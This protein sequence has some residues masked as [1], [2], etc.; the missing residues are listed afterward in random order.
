M[1]ST[2]S[3]AEHSDFYRPSTTDRRVGGGEWSG[4][5]KDGSCDEFIERED[6]PLH[7]FFRDK[8]G[9]PFAYLGAITHREKI[10]T[11]VAIKGQERAPRYQFA[12]RSALGA[13]VVCD[14]NIPL[15]P[16]GN[17]R[18][19]QFHLAALQ[20]LGL[21]TPK[22]FQPTWTT[23]VYIIKPSD[24]LAAVAAPAAPAAPVAPAAASSSSGA[25]GVRRAR[26]SSE[27]SGSSDAGEEEGSRR[28][29]QRSN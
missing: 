26:D 29:R 4:Q 12:Y 14:Q 3:K 13:P 7:W 23:G 16:N 2:R 27:S 11:R 8:E 10:Q 25:R 17:R 20:R 18:L 19:R 6:G 24:R 1:F 15:I 5:R 28:Q 22:G 9:Q 21:P